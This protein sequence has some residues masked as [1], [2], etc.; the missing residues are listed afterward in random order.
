[1]TITDNETS[2]L[3]KKKTAKKIA[4]LDISKLIKSARDSY[5]KKEQGLANQLCT[6]TSISRPSSDDDFV[7]WSKGDH[8][9]TLTHLRGLPFGRIVQISGRPDSGK[10]THAMAFMKEAQDQDCL[11]ILWDAERK[12]SAKRFDTHIGGTSENIL[13]VDTNNIIEGAK[14]VAQLIHAAKEQD[15]T[16]KVLIV[17][18]S[19]GASMNSTEDK[20]EDEDHSKQPGVTAKEITWA[21]KKFNKLINR[22]RS[23]ETG[24]E[25]VAV[26][27]INQSY[28]NIGSVGYKNKGGGELEYLSSLII[29][30]SR[31]GN[32]THTRDGEKY[33]YGIVTRARVSKNHLFDGNESIAEMNLVVSAAGIQLEKDVKS[34]ADISGWDDEEG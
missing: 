17:W 6:G 14:G 9:K 25:T 20:E 18:D 7:L 33:K 28:A 26:L 32:L 30:L 16:V 11:V 1:M 12:F 27:A 5:G 2:V 21:I 3:E 10:S 34:S 8:W 31:K 4:G 29:E 23:R 24:K 19:V 15:E 13:I 22:Y